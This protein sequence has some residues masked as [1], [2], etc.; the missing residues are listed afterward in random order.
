MDFCLKKKK[1]SQ[2]SLEKGRTGAWGLAGEELEAVCRVRGL[3]GWTF[4]QEAI[5]KGR[6]STLA[7]SGVQGCLL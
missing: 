3:V 1:K 6:V 2:C 7:R 4:G 5:G